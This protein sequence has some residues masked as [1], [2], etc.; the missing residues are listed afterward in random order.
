MNP[1]D[2]TLATISVLR[3]NAVVG[4]PDMVADRWQARQEAYDPPGIVAMWNRGRL[5][6]QVML[7]LAA[8]VRDGEAAGHER[9]LPAP[10]DA[11]TPEVRE[12]T[13]REEGAHH[14]DCRLTSAYLEQWH[15]HE[16][17]APTDLLFL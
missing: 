15:A 14:A 5:H 3:D 17:G 4:T 9:R 2:K 13:T 12:R 11:V 10:V 16:S 7:S 8:A 1:C 6:A